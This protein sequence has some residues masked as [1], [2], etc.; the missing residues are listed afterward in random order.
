M[1]KRLLSIAKDIEAVKVRG[2]SEIARAAAEALLLTAKASKARSPDN[3]ASEIE[4]AAKILTG[5]RPTAVSLPN[6]VRFVIHRLREAKKQTPD[7][8]VVREATI[9]ACNEFIENSKVATRRI[10]EIGSNRIS[11]GDVLMTH[12]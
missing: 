5:T 8:E 12:C 10:A 11:D 7:I 3:F 1:S 2:A 4:Q 9:S 6:A